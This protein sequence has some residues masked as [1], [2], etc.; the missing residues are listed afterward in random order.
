MDH[1][2]SD[3]INY[4]LRS[5]VHLGVILCA[6]AVLTSKT[7]RFL[8]DRRR[9]PSRLPLPPGPT[10]YPLIGNVFDMPTSQQWRT[11]AQWA[12]VYGETLLC[13]R[14]QMK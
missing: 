3:T 10:G 11:Y 7:A 14:D 4:A 12:K 6:L 9:N 5:P 13:R 8:S 1:A 2:I